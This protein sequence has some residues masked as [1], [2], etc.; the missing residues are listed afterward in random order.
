MRLARRRRRPRRCAEDP[1]DTAR[2]R[3]RAVRGGDAR[4]GRGGAAREAHAGAKARGGRPRGASPTKSVG[5]PV[6]AERVG[7]QTHG[8]RRGALRVRRVSVGVVRTH[9]GCAVGGGRGRVGGG[10]CLRVPTGRQSA[11]GPDREKQGQK[12]KTLG[13][14]RRKGR[15]K[16][17][18]RRRRAVAARVARVRGRDRARRLARAARVLRVQRERR[19]VP[20]GRLGRVARNQTSRVGSERTR[21]VVRAHRGAAGARRVARVAWSAHR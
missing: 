10:G 1:Q 21:W 19:D 6:E 4:C 13:R 5:D 9:R 20:T 18:G 14:A 7:L 15:R 16:R 3:R 8:G 12:T 11:D 17:H 2:A